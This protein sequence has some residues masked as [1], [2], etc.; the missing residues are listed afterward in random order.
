MTQAHRR[1]RRSK[2]AIAA[3]VIEASIKPTNLTD[4]VYTTR[5]NFNIARKYIEHLIE[6]DLLEYV[7]N[8]HTYQAK[9]KGI[10]YLRTFR[11]AQELYSE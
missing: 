10:E 7:P 5:L 1:V 4:I 3:A 6:N 9:E 8:T 11:R 2:Y